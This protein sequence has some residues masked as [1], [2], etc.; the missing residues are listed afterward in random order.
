MEANRSVGGLVEGGSRAQ[1][2]RLGGDLKRS[3]AAPRLVPD[4]PPQAPA[5][6]TQTSACG[7][8]QAAKN[9]SREKSTME[10]SG[11]R[12]EK[13]GERERESG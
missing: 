5:K 6:E 9:R 3:N 10:A 4:S 13:E 7:C 2:A 8:S 12:K 11:G 1:Y